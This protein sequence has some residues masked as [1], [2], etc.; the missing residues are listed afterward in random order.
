L[1]LGLKGLAAIAA[2]VGLAGGAAA[3]AA[4]GVIHRS[5]GPPSRGPAAGQ[6]RAF[7]AP[8]SAATAV[9]EPA[10]EGL[11]EMP[12]VQIDKARQLISGVGTQGYAVSA[13]PTSDGGVCTAGPVGGGCF[14][15]FDSNGI[16]F[17][18]G[19]DND[20]PA[21]PTDRELIA[22]VASDDVRRIDAATNAGKLRVPLRNNAFV[23]EAPA[24]GVWADALEVTFADGS[25]VRALVSNANRVE[26]IP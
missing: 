17:S 21:S 6:M 8:R 18:T 22:G 23:Y 20:G 4:T 24:V 25:T 10:R 15:E 13:A 26:P 3:V 9:P 12:G 16:T 19:M 11:A 5:D 2:C 14:P 7:A 1:R